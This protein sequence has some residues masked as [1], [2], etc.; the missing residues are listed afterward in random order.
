VRGILAEAERAAGIL[1][2]LLQLSGEGR[3]VR[4]PVSLNELVDRTA[5]LMR[6]NAFRRSDRLMVEK[7]VSVPDVDGDFGQLQQVLLNLLQN[8]SRPSCRRT[9]RPDRRSYCQHGGGRARL[10]VWD[11]GPG[12][13]R[14]SG[15]HLRSIFYYQAAGRGPPASGWQSC[16]GL[17]GSTG[18]R[19][20]FSARQRAARV[21][22][23]SFRRRPPAKDESAAGHR[24]SPGCRRR[25]G[26]GENGIPRENRSPRVLVL[27][28]EADGRRAD[29]GRAA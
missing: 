13:R 4:A 5:G 24:G 2:Q 6:G 18:E 15:A 3:S 17:C 19:S 10:E 1:R 20:M 23:W 28:D 11:D 9:G 26:P 16:W 25:R 7:G 22:W 29:R 27:E 14:D 8:A 21:F 12:V